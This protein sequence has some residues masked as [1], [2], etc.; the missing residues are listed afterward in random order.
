MYN[1]MIVMGKVM[2]WGEAG[3]GEPSAESVKFGITVKYDGQAW[4]AFNAYCLTIPY[5]RIRA[6]RVL[7]LRPRITAAP[8]SPSMRH[9]VL[10]S[11]WSM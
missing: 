7:A 2:K 4:G 8:L 3:E 1:Y 11:T 10:W 6:R 9:L 5:F